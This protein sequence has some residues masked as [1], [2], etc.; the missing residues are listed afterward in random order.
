MLR[1]SVG[2][3]TVSHRRY[4]PK[5]HNFSYPALYTCVDLDRLANEPGFHIS[6]LEGCAD[7][8]AMRASVTD[9]IEQRGLVPP[10]GRIL[11]LA[12]PTFTGKGFNPVVFFFCFGSLLKPINS[13]FIFQLVLVLRFN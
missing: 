12:Q 7:A 10:A 2:Q 5:R 4:V 6:A 9:H 13:L 1:E 11:V 3:G 8:D